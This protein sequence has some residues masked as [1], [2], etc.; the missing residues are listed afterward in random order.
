MERVLRIGQTLQKLLGR[1]VGDHSLRRTNLL[2]LAVVSSGISKL[3]AIGLQGVAIPLVYRAL[4]THNFALYLLLTAALATLALLQFGVGPGLTQAIAKAN[5][6]GDHDE[7]RGA[8]LSAF[9]FVGFS[10]LLGALGLL[11][12]VRAV[13][14]AVLFGA[15]FAADRAEIVRTTDVVVLVMFLYMLA[16]VVDSLLAGYQE[17]VAT[18]LG[19]CAANIASAIGL[20][21]L[22]SRLHPSILQ[23]VL[24][25]YG[26]AILS[27]VVNLLLL[28]VRRPYLIRGS[29]HFNQHNFGLMMRIGLAF[30]FVQGASVLEQHGGTYLVAHVSDPHN[31]DIFG[32]V[33]RATCLA[34]ASVVIFTQP[35]WPAIS[36]ALARHDSKWLLRAI[37]GVRRVLTFA[38][39]A[40][41]FL[42]L[43]IGVW[44]IEHIWRIDLT[45]NRWAV[46]IFGI[47]LLTNTWTHFHYVVLMGLDRVWTV[48]GVI[49]L[50][51]MVML[52]FGV[53]SVPHFG[54]VGMA[55]AYLLANICVPALVLPQILS[56]RIRRLAAGS[57]S[58]NLQPNE[59]NAAEKS[60]VG[61]ESLHHDY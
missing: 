52:A 30:W 23:V 47:Y 38:A 49:L 17:Q 34:T 14:P 33:Y 5:A 53:A 9:L 39:V 25:M 42:M 59:L 27:R 21:V 54:A 22:C 3:S 57:P 15:S 51:N 6:A 56:K 2:R 10:A 18:N 45:G 12:L 4:G 40:L 13:S 7:E 55:G 31:T 35:L 60:A 24:V 37:D 32:V 58:G 16:G 44:G 36:D 29:V 1:G 41:A 61:I 48:A 28:F 43:T 8:Y 50:E 46:Y 26:G 20:L 19:A 11:E